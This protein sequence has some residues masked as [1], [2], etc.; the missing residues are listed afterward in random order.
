MPGVIG[1][2]AAVA[3]MAFLV[4]FLTRTRQRERRPLLARENLF[5]LG[6]A[7]LQRFPDLLGMDSLERRL[8]WAGRPYQL[9]SAEFVG[10]R[11]ISLIV[12]LLV[13]L[14][15]GGMAF[16]VLGGLLGAVYPDL[17]LNALLRK[18][19]LRIE[20]DLAQFLDYWTAAVEAGLDLM[21]AVERVS[22]RVTGPLAQEF[23][24]ALQEVDVGFPRAVALQHV[25]ERCGVP[26]LS[27]VISVL[28]S[29]DRFGTSV[30]E[31]LRVDYRELWLQRTARARMRAAQV[32]V[33]MRGPLLFLILP[34]LLV[35]M[36]SPV[37]WH[38]KT[39]F[40]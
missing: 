19:Q 8:I 14:L 6:Q 28:V 16:A 38:L 25:S 15:L 23:H 5:H 11:A 3:V 27:Q 4:G 32:G 17:W 7:L 35:M 22:K 39:L 40:G 30:A 21:P 1:V 2:L 37:L 20:R 9:Q 24:L 18:R 33:A 10:V 36:L 29:A 12:G 31:Q 34:G 13:G 26:D